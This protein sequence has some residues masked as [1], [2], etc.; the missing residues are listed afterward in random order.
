MYVHG[1]PLFLMPAC[2]LPKRILAS[3][4]GWFTEG[5]ETPDLN[6]AKALFDEIGIQVTLARSSGDA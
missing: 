3:I 2:S 4:F 1:F 5:L 6:D